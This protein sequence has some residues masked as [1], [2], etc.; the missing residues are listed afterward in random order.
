MKKINSSL[1][2]EKFVIH[3]PLAEFGGG[4]P[5]VALSNRMVV[6]LHDAEDKVIE[7]FVVRAHNMHSCVRMVAMLIQAFERGGPIVN[8]QIPFNWDSIWDVVVNDFEY[9]HNPSRWIAVYKGGKVVYEKGARNPFLDVI[10]KC[11]E[12][13]TE[14][15][16]RTIALAEAAFKKTGKVVKID[17]DSNVALVVNFEKNAGRCA[18]ILRGAS[19]T[20]TFNFSAAARPKKILSIPQC[21]SGAAAFLEGVQLAFTVGM[22]SEKSALGIIERFTKEEK[23]IKDGKRQ[24]GKLSAEIINMESAFEIRYRPERPEFRKI[25]MDAERLAKKILARPL[26]GRGEEPGEGQEV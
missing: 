15:Y 9:A 12:V 4:E 5:V 3:D 17:Y 1:L 22:D 13:N 26:R 10:E 6:D 20:T 19:S 18:I 8:R 11:D 24:L 23:R 16:D 25:M 21:L 7:T 14:E 2:R